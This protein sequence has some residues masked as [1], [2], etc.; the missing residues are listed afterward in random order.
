MIRLKQLRSKSSMTQMR[1]TWEKK[2]F[3]TMKHTEKT[4]GSLSD[5]TETDMTA[6]GSSQRVF[7]R[8]QTSLA[9]SGSSTSLRSKISGS[10][11]WMENIK[12]CSPTSLGWIIRRALPL[13]SNYANSW[14][15]TNCI[16]KSVRSSQIRKW[17]INSSQIEPNI[18][19][20]VLG[21]HMIRDKLLD[22]C[23]CLSL[24]RRCKRRPQTMQ[25]LSS[26]TRPPTTLVIRSCKGP[27]HPNLRLI[28][29][30]GAGLLHHQNMKTKLIP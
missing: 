30:T 2:L 3:W 13:L 29:P 18:C 11:S 21:R 14:N 23:K 5:T 17:E 6:K 9:R 26:L 10:V 16:K 8:I 7:S 20:V 15:I 25:I 12:R 19:L 22:A 28:W 4:F 1:N 24:V 27:S